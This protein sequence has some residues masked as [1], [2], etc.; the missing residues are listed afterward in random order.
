M[1]LLPTSI[2]RMVRQNRQYRNRR[3]RFIDNLRATDSFLVGHPKSGN[4]W[5]AYMLSIVENRDID[6]HINLSN[7]G[8]HVPVIHDRDFIID[9]FSRLRTPRIF[10]NE[11]PLFPELYPVT[12][13]LI[14]DPRAALLSYYHHCIHDTG[15]RD[16]TMDDFIDEMLEFGCIK[17]LEPH[18]VRWDRQVKGWLDRQKTQR[19]EFVKYE[20]LKQDQYGTLIRMLDFLEIPHDH[21]L[22]DLAVQ[23]S[24]FSSMRKEEEV[25]GSESFSGERGSKGYFV[26]KGEVDSWKSEMPASV[27][28]KIEHAFGDIMEKVGYAL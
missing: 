3:S 9:T 18:L 14:R 10:R 11:S 22:I 8:E 13:Y 20:D 28:R 2:R 25:Y 1:K 24:G 23:R 21:D 5:T 4:T 15:N 19:V 17:S 27:V 7:I 16:W 26:R 12:I 6:H